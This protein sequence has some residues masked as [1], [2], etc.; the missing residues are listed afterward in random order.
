MKKRKCQILAEQ[1]K[2]AKKPAS[3]RASGGKSPAKRPP[4][5][6]AAP[7]HGRAKPT[8]S[9]IRQRNQMRAVVLFAC[10]IFFGCLAL[11]PGDS[12][13]NW[14]H[15]AILGLFGGWAVLWQIGRAHV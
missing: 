7:A 5:G 2:T 11:I 13:W 12:L 6:K 4:A 15:N 8:A 10:A 14:A 9:Q 3:S 1:R